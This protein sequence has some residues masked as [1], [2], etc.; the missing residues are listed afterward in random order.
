MNIFLLFVFN[1]IMYVYI[2]KLYIMCQILVEMRNRN[3]N[4]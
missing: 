2:D 4:L 1:L 3:K